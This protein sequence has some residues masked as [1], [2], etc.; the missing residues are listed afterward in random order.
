MAPSRT[1]LPNLTLTSR[2]T[3]SDVVCIGCSVYAPLLSPT[4]DPRTIKSRYTIAYFFSHRTK[5]PQLDYKLRQFNKRENRI[6]EN[7]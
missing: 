7:H 3:H 5:K 6:T 4:H 1:N 2:P